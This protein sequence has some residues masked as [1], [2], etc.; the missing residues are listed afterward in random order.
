MHECVIWLQE[1]KGGGGGVRA[2]SEPGTGQEICECLNNNNNNNNNNNVYQ[3]DA[4]NAMLQLVT[5][6]Y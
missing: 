4:Y 6:Q 3:Q 5:A 2:F 1:K